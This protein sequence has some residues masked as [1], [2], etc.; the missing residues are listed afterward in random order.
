[1]NIRL[2]VED[3]PRLNLHA[4]GLPGKDGADG[5]PGPQGQKGDKGD[6]GER[7]PQGERGEKGEKGDTYTLTAE[8]QAAIATIVIGN[9]TNLDEGVF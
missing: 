9:L 2:H 7:G 4:S 6:Q 5:L 3:T 1:M 8:D